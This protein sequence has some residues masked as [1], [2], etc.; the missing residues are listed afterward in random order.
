MRCT[1]I[2][3]S[4]SVLRSGPSPAPQDRT[5]TECPKRAR[6]LALCQ[7]WVP[8]P[9]RAVS[10]GYS[11]ETKQI[12]TAQCPRPRRLLDETHPGDRILLAVHSL[13]R[14]GS[15]NA[16]SGAALSSDRTT[17]RPATRK[18][19][20]WLLPAGVAPILESRSRHLA[21]FPSTDPLF[22]GTGSAD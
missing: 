19:R 5:C 2:P 20:T 11:C 22:L 14:S 18:P 9:P 4:I 21:D 16:G 6:L 7:V 17:R 3:F 10:G 8:I 15:A 12:L 13:A 1:V